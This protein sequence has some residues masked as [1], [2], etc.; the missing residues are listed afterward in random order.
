MRNQVMFLAVAAAVVAPAAI[1]IGASQI[2]VPAPMSSQAKSYLDQA[3]SLFRAEHINSS[4]MDWPALNRDAYAAAANAQTTADTY[5]AIRFIIKKLGEKHTFFLEP[6]RA[7][8]AMTG[9]PSGNVSAPPFQPPQAL[10]LPNGIGVI[11]L[12]EFTGS[13]EQGQLYARTGQTEIGRLKMEGACKFVVDLRPDEGGNMYP[14][15]TAVSGLLGDGVLGTFENAHKQ[16]TPWIL[17][18]GRATVG[19]TSDAP[20][21]TV[22]PNSEAVPV[23]VLIGPSTAS[24]GEFTAM[25]FEGRPTTRFF[26]A[27]SAGYV[28]ANEPMPLSDGAVIVMTGGWGIDRR[29]KMYTDAM[30]PDEN[31]GA[32]AAAMDAAVRWLSAQPCPLAAKRR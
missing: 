1:A 12:H 15:L 30:Q 13:P 20:P 25:S 4:K 24:A 21:A 19:A 29:G 7:K 16:F 5:P 17:V 18:N 8:A 31:T 23:A 2:T 3:I 22:R 26:G 32:G 27:P 14:M 11:T 6:D 10:R 9:K 28:T